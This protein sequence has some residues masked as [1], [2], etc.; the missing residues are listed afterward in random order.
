[1]H[2]EFERFMQLAEAFGA[3]RRRWPLEHQALYEHFALTEPG[4]RVL[5]QAAELDALLDDLTPRAHDA[6]RPVRIVRAARVPARRSLAWLSAAYAATAVLGF[7]LGFTVL[8]QE[9]DELM[10]SDRIYAISTI[11]EFL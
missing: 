4:A 7:A 9:E 8:S 11:E 3:A 2:M 1:M 5:A 6:V 10:Y